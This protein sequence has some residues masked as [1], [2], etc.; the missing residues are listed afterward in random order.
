M[1]HTTITWQGS[2]YDL[3]PLPI[4]ASTRRYYRINDSTLGNLIVCIDTKINSDFITL[5]NYFLENGIPVPKVIG[6][7]EE[8]EVIIQTD[9]GDR[10]LAS[11]GLNEYL[12]FLPQILNLLVILQSL[13]PHPIISNRR[14]DFEKLN[15]ET[16]L[17]L[18]KLDRLSQDLHWDFMVPPEFR[19]F[20]EETN[21]YLDRHP[22]Q[23]LAHRD[24]HSRNIL[25][26]DEKD[27]KSGKIGIIDFQDA[28]LGTPQYDLASILY[29]AYYPISRTDRRRFMNE[30]RSKSKIDFYKFEETFYLQAL[31]RSFKA[32]GTYLTQVFEKKNPKFE[33]SLIQCLRNLE[34][35]SQLGLLPDAIYLTVDRLQAIVKDFNFDSIYQSRDQKN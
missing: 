17:T 4:E 30:F 20:L 11:F 2:K 35:I 21:E 29:D 18:E 22:N 16:A 33:D 10:D 26:M 28:R 24:F 12:E 13:E 3:T 14:F 7:I 19:I 15:Y 27:Q 23:V 9:L 32:L 25:I 6:T 5:S 34:E 31:Q 1:N 8:S